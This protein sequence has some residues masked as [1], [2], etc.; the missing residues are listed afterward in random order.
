MK[1]LTYLLIITLFTVACGGTN[2]KQEEKSSLS[3]RDQIRLKQYQVQGA[4][5][6]ATYCA[7]CHQQDGKGLASLY[8]PLAGSDYLLEDMARAACIIKNGQSK[9]IVVNGVTYNQ[10]MP[11]NPITNLE[12]AE[13]LT[14]IGNAWGNE[15][16]LIGVKDVDKYIEECGE[17]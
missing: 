12:I 4:K 5:I 17:N 1:K 16:G 15:A 14:F 3:S 2:E 10:M 13:V 8:P 6:Y 11:G 7:N 9:E